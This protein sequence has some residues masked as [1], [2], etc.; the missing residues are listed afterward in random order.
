MQILKKI[1]KDKN[2]DKKERKYIERKNDR[3]KYKKTGKKDK[4]RKAKRN[5][6][7][8]QLSQI[9]ILSKNIEYMLSL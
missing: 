5:H 9:K 6:L 8:S 3:E 7:I 1:E 4:K 2:I